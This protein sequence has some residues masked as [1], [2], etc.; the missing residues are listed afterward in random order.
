M[1]GRSALHARGAQTKHLRCC[2]VVYFFSDRLLRENVLNGKM[3]T[4]CTY[5][6]SLLFFTLSLNQ[7]EA[8]DGLLRCYG[9][10]YLFFAPGHLLAPP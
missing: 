9:Q 5:F 10:F 7:S 4:V 2:C 1:A 3:M 8:N 6:Q